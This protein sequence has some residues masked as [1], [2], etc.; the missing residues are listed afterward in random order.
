MPKPKRWESLTDAAKIETLH[1]NVSDLA[2]A[3]KTIRE[4]LA[5]IV[6]QLAKAAP[7]T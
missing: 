5:R 2:G 3:I 6:G 4:D 7:K 1:R